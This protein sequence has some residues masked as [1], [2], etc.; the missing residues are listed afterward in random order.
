M[1]TFDIALVVL[2]SC[3]V[4][5]WMVAMMEAPRKNGH[6][7]P[8]VRPPRVTPPKGPRGAHRQQ[9]QRCGKPTPGVCYCDLSDLAAANTKG[10]P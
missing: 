10:T 4:L 5:L 2:A 3:M 7:S 1:R 6:Q 8:Q 9:C